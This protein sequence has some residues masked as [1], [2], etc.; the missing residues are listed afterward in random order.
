M[1]SQPRAKEPTLVPS[2]DVDGEHFG[3]TLWQHLPAAAAGY[4]GDPGTAALSRA[5]DG[6]RFW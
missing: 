3:P 4:V 1:A 6:Q 2:T 5:G